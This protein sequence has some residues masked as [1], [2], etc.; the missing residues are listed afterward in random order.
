M[1]FAVTPWTQAEQDALYAYLNALAEP[2]YLK[3]HL[4]IVPTAVGALGVRVPKLREIAREIA[5]GDYQGFFALENGACYELTMI[6]G[7]TLGYCK[8]GIDTLL[9]ATA[10]YVPYITNWALC[11]S[12][13][14]NL[15]WV[16]KDLGRVWEFLQPYL[17]SREEFPARFGT[18]MLMDHYICDEYIDRVLTRLVHAPYPQYY[19][20]MAVAWA[21]SVCYVKY[22]EKTLAAMGEGCTLDDFTFNKALQKMC[23]SYRVSPEEKTMLRA[24]KRK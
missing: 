11:D 10:G 23:E 22:K 24:M 18:V 21:L 8:A 3:F 1:S 13:C 7:L 16:K 14:G 9:E 5:K 6:H 20:Q 15:K 19:A 2:E 12:P 17:D 4:G